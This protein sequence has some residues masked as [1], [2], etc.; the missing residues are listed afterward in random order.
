M[1]SVRNAENFR[2][3]VKKSFRAEEYRIAQFVTLHFIKIKSQLLQAAADAVGQPIALRMQ[4]GYD[5]SYFFMA[6]FMAD[7]VAFHAKRL[8]D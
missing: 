8:R 6:S 4:P 2:L 1:R 7:H 5:H 3:R